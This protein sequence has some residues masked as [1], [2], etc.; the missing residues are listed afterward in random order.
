MRTLR[1]VD[2]HSLGPIRIFIT[3]R[4]RDNMDADV[5]AVPEN[6]RTAGMQS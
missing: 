2:G 3:P 6:M 4:G 1:N 5:R